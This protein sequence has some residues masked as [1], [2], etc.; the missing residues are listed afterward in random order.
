[1]G[2]TLDRVIFYS[3]M[4]FAWAYQA[5]TWTR[6]KLYDAGI[7]RENRFDVPVVSVGNITAGG[8]GKTPHVEF[9]IDQLCSD[10]KIAVLSRGYKR[11]TKGFVLASST[12]TPNTIGDEP[13]QI[14]QKFGKRITVAVCEDRTK[15]IDAL[16]D[17]DKNINLIL[18]DDAFQHRSVKPKVNILLIDKNRPINKDNPLPL[19]RLRES[20]NAIYRADIVILTNTY[21][22]MLPLTRRNLQKN[23]RLLDNQK[24]F[25]SH[26]HYEDLQPVFPEEAKYSVTLGQLTN[27]DAVMLLSGI[28]NPRAFI[29]YVNSFPCKCTVRHFPDHHDFTR[30]DC[31][32]IAKEYNE[33][34]GAHKL[35][36]TTEKDAVRL[37]HNP[38]FPAN[39]KPLVFYLPIYVTVSDS[40]DQEKFMETLRKAID[41]KPN[42]LD[43]EK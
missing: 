39:L 7:F 1:M 27:T 34:K 15:G 29:H 43:T 23:A 41:E 38:Y 10:Y 35:I 31:E 25:Y 8:T 11:H 20:P 3:L 2:S 42:P 37:L 5:V 21:E 19:G 17:Y 30:R 26:V 18:L 24:M 36:I 9:L 32:Q 14:Y 13:Y 12:S 40:A 6:N 33:L 28:A 22:D 16:L 4:P